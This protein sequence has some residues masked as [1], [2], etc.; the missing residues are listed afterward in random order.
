MTLVAKII[1]ARSTS[2]ELVTQQWKLKCFHALFVGDLIWCVRLASQ[3]HEIQC[4]NCAV[5]LLPSFNKV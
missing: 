3:S 1:W 5:G 4:W 2:C